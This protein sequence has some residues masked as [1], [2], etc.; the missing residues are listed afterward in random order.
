MFACVRV[1]VFAFTS[2]ESISFP[3]RRTTNSQKFAK[4]FGSSG[5][6]HGE[7]ALPF[8]LKR[9]GVIMTQLHVRVSV[10]CVC[11]C[12][13]CVLHVVCACVHVCA[14]DCAWACLCVHVYVFMNVSEFMPEG[15]RTFSNA[16]A[17]PCAYKARVLTIWD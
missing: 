6:V 12:V 17:S 2:I 10:V 3:H 1:C 4:S 8:A 16:F 11:V 7:A 5:G 14:C 13:L 9:C 15:I